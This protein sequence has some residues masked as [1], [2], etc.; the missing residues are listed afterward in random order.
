MRSLLFTSILVATLAG[1][2]SSGAEP[3]GGAVTFPREP[4]AKVTTDSGAWHIEVRVSPQ[5][6]PVR[7]V[8]TVELTITDGAG[9]PVPSLVIGITPWMSAHGHGA[10]TRPEIKD[11][12]AGNYVATDVN[13]YMPGRWDLRITLATPAG[14]TTDRATAT[15]DV[16]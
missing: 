11:V 6:P 10:S 9:K 5:Q 12:G 1:C 15:L 13:L 3:E 2:G 14:E 8:N 16:P 7:G 4:L